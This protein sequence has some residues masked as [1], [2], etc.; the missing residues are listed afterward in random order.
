MRHLGLVVLCA[1]GRIGF[2]P[3]VASTNADA[4]IGVCS[5]PAMAVPPSGGVGGTIAAQPVDDRVGA[6]GG[7]GFN[8]LLYEIDIPANTGLLI[9]AD[10]PNTT[11]NSLMYLRSDCS[12]PATELVCDQDGGLADGAAYRLSSVAP[13]RKFVIFDGEMRGG[14]IDGK[15][16]RLLPLDATCNGDTARDRCAP[17]LRCDT[18][19]NTCVDAGCTVVET[20]TMTGMYSRM[21]S[22]TTGGPSFHA[23]TCGEGNDGGARAPE[24]IYR[25]QLSTPVSDLHAT[26]NDGATDHDTLV[27]VREGCTGMELACSDDINAT[28]NYHADVRTGPLPAGDYY[29]FIDG[30]STRAGVSAVLIE[31][32]P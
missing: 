26:T 31:I 12:D 1:C 22:T 7:T 30:F 11:A 6:C 15:I 5:A 14:V 29:I 17:G 23:G 27:Y 3:T 28:D 4:P 32:T 8:E 18:G 19:S 2:D 10:G 24:R 16:Q 25:V 20:F 9:S 13:G 21:T